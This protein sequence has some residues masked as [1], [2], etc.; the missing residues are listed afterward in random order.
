MTLLSWRR[1]RLASISPVYNDRGELTGLRTTKPPLSMIGRMA[2]A[3]RANAVTNFVCVEV[4]TTFFVAV[5]RLVVVL[6]PLALTTVT[7]PA[8][9]AQPEGG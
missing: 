8:C 2:S 9:R 7:G 5:T 4:V 1:V 6:V 3:L